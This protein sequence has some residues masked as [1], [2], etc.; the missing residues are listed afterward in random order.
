M[1]SYE[2]G[3]NSVWSWLVTSASV[4]AKPTIAAAATTQVA[5]THHGRRTTKRPSF[6]NNASS[7]DPGRYDPRVSPAREQ[8]SGPAPDGAGIEGF[9]SISSQDVHS[10]ATSRRL[11]RYRSRVAYPT[12]C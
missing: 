7:W 3:R 6:S 8:P 11:R 12:L 1:D 4:G 2:S 10:D 5:I 9:D